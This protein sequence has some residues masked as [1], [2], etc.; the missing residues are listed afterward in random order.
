MPDTLT[1]IKSFH[2]RLLEILLHVITH[3]I[4]HNYE[5]IIIIQ[6]LW[7]GKWGLRQL[8]SQGHMASK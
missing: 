2:P 3:L 8:F 6:L 1:Y 5:E 7:M 4:Q